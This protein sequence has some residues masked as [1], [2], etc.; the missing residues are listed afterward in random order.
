MIGG[1]KKQK[2][3]HPQKTLD[4]ILSGQVTF[5]DRQEGMKEGNVRR[6]ARLVN[7]CSV[8]KCIQWSVNMV[9]GG[10]TDERIPVVLD[11][12]RFLRLVMVGGLVME[13][14]R[15]LAAAAAGASAAAAAAL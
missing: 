6:L 2:K 5:R 14:R 7:V 10:E 12:R 13:Q 3:K 11:P 1:A 15:P 4:R 9:S 8:K